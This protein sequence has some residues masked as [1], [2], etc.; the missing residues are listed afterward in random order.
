MSNYPKISPSIIKADG[1]HSGEKCILR[2]HATLIGIICSIKLTWM[3]SKALEFTSFLQYYLENATL[4][5][6]FGNK[7]IEMA[8][9]T[10]NSKLLNGST[11]TY[12]YLKMY[13]NVLLKHNNRSVFSRLLCSRLHQSHWLK[14]HWQRLASIILNLLNVCF[15]FAL[16]PFMLSVKLHYWCAIPDLASV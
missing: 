8:N 12:I 4:P 1:T 5:K 14:L 13:A 9:F 16:R 10:N 15:Y 3:C 6:K 11:Y 2:R 7:L